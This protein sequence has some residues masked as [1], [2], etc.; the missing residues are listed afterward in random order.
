MK[1]DAPYATAAFVFVVSSFYFAAAFPKLAI[2]APLAAGFLLQVPT[3][4]LARLLPRGRDHQDAQSLM[5]LVLLVIGSIW[6]AMSPS[7]VRF[8]AYAALL[9]PAPFVMIALLVPNNRWLGPV[10]SHF[11]TSD[12]EVWLTIDDGPAGDTPALLD[13]LDRQGVHATFFVKGMLATPEWVQTITS[14]GQT[15]GNHSQTHPSGTFWCLPPRALARE[16]DACAAAI[17]PTKLFRSPVGHKN[18]FLHG[19]LR[20]RGLKL[21]AFSARAYDAILRDPDRIARSI[22][23]QVQPGAIIVLHQG[24]PWSLAAIEQTIEQ[25]RERGYAFV[26]PALS[27]LS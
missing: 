11:V 26:V 18:F 14:R 6:F 13:L 5:M 19:L 24:R 17:P 16:I 4:F 21:I 27:R 9:L 20:E 1:V 2:V 23:R 12:R 8:V 25:V 10:V 7:W 22:A 3:F 15:I